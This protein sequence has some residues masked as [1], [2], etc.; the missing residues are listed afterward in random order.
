[1]QIV[2]ANGKGGSGK[3]TVVSALAQIMDADIVDHDNQGTLRVTS[4]IS[5]FNEPVPYGKTTKPIV[6]HDTP[7]YN[8]SSFKSLFEASDLIIIPCNVS[9]A[10]LMAIGRVV[11]DLRELEMQKKTFILF[12][13]VRKPHNNTYKAI[14]E[15]FSTNYTDIKKIKTELSSLNSFLEIFAKPL[16]GQALKETENLYLEIKGYIKGT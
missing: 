12:N 7:P 5:G 9:Y 16:S 14:K 2:V 13:R 10:D 15:A 11:T 1:M 3:S 8:M 6:I 4:S